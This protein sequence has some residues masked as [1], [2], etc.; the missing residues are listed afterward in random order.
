MKNQYNQEQK[1]IGKDYVKIADKFLEVRIIQTEKYNKRGRWNK[2]MPRARYITEEEYEKG[3]VKGMKYY[4]SLRL[5]SVKCPVCGS[6]HKNF[7]KVVEHTSWSGKVK[8]L[9]E[10]WSGDT[11]EEKPGHLY[12]IELDNL[13]IVR[14]KRRNSVKRDK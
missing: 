5:E 1:L 12:L 8:L 7:K 14:I 10:C 3:V 2:P 13:P 9:V 4:N 6:V 11:N